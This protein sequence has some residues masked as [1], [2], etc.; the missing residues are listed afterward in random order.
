M[1]RRALAPTAL[2]LILA[3]GACSVVNAPDKPAAPDGEGGSS[4]TTTSTGGTGGSVSCT[5]PEVDCGGVCADTME[6]V[7]HCGGCGNAC[8]QGEFCVNAQCRADCGTLLQCGTDCAD[9]LVDPIHCGGCNNACGTMAVCTGGNC[10]ACASTELICNNVCTDITTDTNNC[11]SCGNLCANMELCGGGTCV[12]AL[13]SCREILAASPTAAD[14]V[15][16]I[17]PNGG[18]PGDAFDTYCDMT[19]DGGGWT[20]VLN[21][22]VDS[23]NTGQPDLNIAGG[24]F[25]NARAGNWNFDINLFWNNFTEVAFAAKENADCASCAIAGYD[26]A[27]KAP[28]PAGGSWSRTCTGTSTA[29]TVTKL[30]GLSASQTFQ[31][32]MCAA[33]LGWGSCGGNVCHYGIHHQDTASDGSWSQNL[34]PE[35]HFP[36]AYS[37][38]ASFGD[39]NSSPS[40]WCRSCAGGLPGLMNQSSTC[41]SDSSANARSRWTIWLR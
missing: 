4:T 38:Y 1:L 2:S 25:D 6:D 15:Y 19:T 36:A 12:T 14:G 32:Y 16:S 22:L 35:M 26:S 13:P 3:F 40:A 33:S 20:L 41:C 23:D 9:I 34:A 27:I 39:V 10:V 29:S 7:D 18:D 5:S 37:S 8:A 11:G 30:V 21:R 17:D 28:K 24:T 31:G